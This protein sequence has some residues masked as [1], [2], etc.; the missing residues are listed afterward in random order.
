MTY[1][2]LRNAVGKAP[3][4]FKNPGASNI[5]AVRVRAGGAPTGGVYVNALCGNDAVTYAKV[6]I[7][8]VAAPFMDGFWNEFRFLSF[9]MCLGVSLDDAYGSFA[10]LNIL[11]GF[12]V[13]LAWVEY[14]IPCQITSYGV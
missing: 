10:G 11:S 4:F 2:F 12:D 5:I 3:V 6:V 1:G 8:L 13:D 14:P 7:N 9:P